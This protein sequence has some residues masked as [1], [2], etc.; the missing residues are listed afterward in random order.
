MSNYTQYTCK[1]RVF[2]ME[3]KKQYNTYEYKLIQIYHRQNTE[4]PPLHLLNNTCI[5]RIVNTNVISL[6]LRY[7]DLIADNFG[8]NQTTITSRSNKQL[9][10]KTGQQHCI[11]DVILV[12]LYVRTQCVSNNTFRRFAKFSETFR[13]EFQGKLFPLQKKKIRFQ[14]NTYITFEHTL[15]HAQIYSLDQF[16]T[17]KHSQRVPIYTEN[18]YFTLAQN[19]KIS[20]LQLRFRTHFVVSD[21]SLETRFNL[22]LFCVVL[23]IRCSASV[24]ENSR[25]K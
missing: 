23:G 9:K 14:L 20:L 1:Y 5:Y 7:V 16:Q 19:D 13:N 12:Y 11:G 24:T 25:H 6:S 8:K 4:M 15:E 22:H 18:Q 21:F 2:N 17:T 10:V 3:T